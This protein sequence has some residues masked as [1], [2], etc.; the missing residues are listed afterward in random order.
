MFRASNESYKTTHEQI[1]SVWACLDWVPVHFVRNFNIDL[2]A[3]TELPPGHMPGALRSTGQLVL[4]VLD[5][6][7]ALLRTLLFDSLLCFF[8]TNSLFSIHAA[9][10]ACFFLLF[11]FFISLWVTEIILSSRPCGSKRNRVATVFFS[12]SLLCLGN[13]MKQPSKKCLKCPGVV[14]IR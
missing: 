3:L 13:S 11:F 5:T 8:I 6:D 10:I 2:A 14:L 1:T 7:G 9:T 12:F 4:D